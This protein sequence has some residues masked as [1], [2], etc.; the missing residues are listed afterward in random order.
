MN[1]HKRS[2]VLFKLFGDVVH[3]PPQILDVRIVSVTY[4]STSSRICTRLIIP[5]SVGRL[6][7]C[8]EK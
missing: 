7:V 3:V 4:Q 8:V 1:E 5:I 2:I 6:I